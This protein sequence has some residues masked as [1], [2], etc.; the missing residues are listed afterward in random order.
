[1]LL[2]RSP[3]DVVHGKHPFGEK[4]MGCK[5]TL[6]SGGK[7]RQTPFSSAVASLLEH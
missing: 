7:K 4:S 5:I 3:I 2:E 6:L 1:L